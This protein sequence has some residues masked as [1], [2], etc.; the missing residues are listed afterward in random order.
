MR[1]SGFAV[2]RLAGRVLVV[3]GAE[4]VLA[5]WTAEP[6]TGGEPVVQAPLHRHQEDEAWYVLTGA[7]RIRIGRD[8][9]EVP[10]GGA[11]VV[12]GGVVHTY[13]NPGTTAARY[14]LV[15]G[16]RTYALI[17]AIHERERTP[18]Q[19]RELFHRYGAELLD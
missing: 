10:A 19:L 12:P 5:E 15:M 9:V 17:E 3:A 13:W 4:V 8:V 14:L 2:P 7:L 1:V 6:V 18:A 11:A 16:P